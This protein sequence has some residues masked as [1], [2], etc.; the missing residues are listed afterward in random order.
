M[1]K[2]VIAMTKQQSILTETAKIYLRGLTKSL[3][4]PETLDIVQPIMARQPAMTCR[5]NYCA[6]R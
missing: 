6:S 4:L 2:Q 5:N 3:N 1:L